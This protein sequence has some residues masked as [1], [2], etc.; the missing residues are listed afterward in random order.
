[1]AQKVLVYDTTLR[2]GM[3]GEG[4]SLSADEKLRVAHAL[5]ALGVHLIEAGFPAS[6]P[7]EEELF[8]LLS[9]ERFE[10]AE[11]AAFGMTRRR[12]LAAA[13]DPALRLLADCFAPVCT[14]VG[15]TWSLHLEKVTKVDPEEN[16]RMIADSVAFL[17]RRGQARDLRRRAL[18]RR[19]PRRR[20]LRAALP[21]RGRRGGR[22]ERDAVRHERL[23]AAGRG[24]RGHRARW[25]AELG[26]RARSASTPTT[27]PAAAWRTRSWPWRRGARL[28][29]GTMNGYGE[30]CG[31]ANLVSIL[32]ALQLK[33]GYECVAPERLRAPHRDR[34]PG[35]RA[36]QRH[37]EPQPA[38][39]R[40]PTPS[41]TRAAC[42][43]PA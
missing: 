3:Q 34:A 20:R 29:Q 9:R 10:H 37:A 6:N 32:P 22:R 24:G 26:E 1:M 23:V 42:T 8:E 39:R 7:K 15:K 33:L 25:S 30:R 36:L 21:A 31:N 18:L 27:T 16:L 43:W 12:D 11:V 41:P 40:A 2:D 35:R 5:D 14:L 28:V 38:V 19:L 17:V 4:M 13:D